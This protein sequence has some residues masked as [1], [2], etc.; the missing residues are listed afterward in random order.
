MVGLLFGLLLVLLV[1][2]VPVTFALGLAAIATI[3]QGEM[4]PMLIVPQEMIRSINS[5]PLLAIPFF[6]LAGFLMQTGGISRRLVD[7]SNTLVGSMTGGLAMVAIVTSLFFAAISGSGTATTAAVGA[8]LIPAMIAK[9][10][11][12]DYAAAN[13]AASGALGV[14]IPP[15]IPLILYAISANVSVGDMFMAGVFP[16]LIVALSLMVYAY[17]YALS[18]PHV[19]EEPSSLRE[20]LT[21]GRKA[22]LAIFMPVLVLGGIYGGVF[23]PTEAA[24]IAV[25]Y[26]FVVGGVV[27]RELRLRDIPEIL[28]KSAIT[29][30]VVLSIIAT[31]GLYG[32][33]ILSLQVPA[34]LSDF[35]VGAID[36]WILFIILV[37]VLLLF[38]G[39]FLEAAAAILI[40][41][42]ILLP[43]AMTFGFH[44][45]HFGIIMVVNLAMGMFTPPVGLNLFVASQI[46]GSS[47]ARLSRYVIPFVAI[48]F[49]NV[50]LISFVP[51]LSMWMT[52]R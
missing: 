26:S 5:F 27:F 16:G 1:L 44:P 48:V 32:R 4:M 38:V 6:V 19:R 13:Q 14:I 24:V 18:H 43:I 3:W 30:A 50:L 17:V 49:V 23:T 45:I 29:S 37:N 25:V 40:F 12:S 9:G 42:P 47:I 7:F 46:S 34:M 31:A 36:S 39:M 2:G 8:I 20:I 41:T 21:A 28:R 51:A 52:G 35:V 22:I 11:S 10:Y 33:I 15:N